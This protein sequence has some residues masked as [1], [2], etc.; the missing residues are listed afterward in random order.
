[1][2]HRWDEWESQFHRKLSWLRVKLVSLHF[3]VIFCKMGIMIP[4]FHGDL[5]VLNRIYLEIELSTVPA[6]GCFNK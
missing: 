1:M 3:S 6:M 2:E 5:K 4:I